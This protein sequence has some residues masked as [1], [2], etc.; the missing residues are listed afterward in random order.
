MAPTI[1][2]H[3]Y[4]LRMG[5]F[6]FTIVILWERQRAFLVFQR[7]HNLC[8]FNMPIM[9]HLFCAQKWRLCF[10]AKEPSWPKSWMRGPRDEWFGVKRPLSILTPI[11]TIR[12]VFAQ[13]KKE[14]V[15]PKSPKLSVISLGN[16]WCN[17]QSCHASKRLESWQFVILLAGKNTHLRTQ[18]P[19]SVHPL[20][21]LFFFPLERNEFWPPSNLHFEVSDTEI[22][23][24]RAT[25]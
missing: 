12:T 23:P 11:I 9:S 18:S 16:N 13:V 2:S 17:F 15:K 25:F 8:V 3:L 5:W 10:D 24:L 22:D 14:F 4:L 19:K 21:S 1:A 6:L 7:I 20:K